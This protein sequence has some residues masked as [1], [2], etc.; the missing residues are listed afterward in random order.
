MTVVLCAYFEFA[1]PY[2]IHY[3]YYYYEHFSAQVNTGTANALM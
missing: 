1:T 2:T 3:Y